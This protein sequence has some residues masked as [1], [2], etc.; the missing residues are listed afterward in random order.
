MKQETSG[1]SKPLITQ[2]KRKLILLRANN[3]TENIYYIK[4]THR[5]IEPNNNVFLI[6]PLP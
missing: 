4:P 1:A 2:L 5:N 6:T 3:S